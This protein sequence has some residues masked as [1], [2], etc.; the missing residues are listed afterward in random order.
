MRDGVPYTDDPVMFVEFT[1]KLGVGLFKVQGS[2]LSAS[3]EVIDEL[4]TKD[5][6]EGFLVEQIV[7]LAWDPAFALRAQSTSRY[8][9]VQMEVG[10]ELLI[11]GMQDSDK[12]QS[13][14]QFFL[15]KLDQ[16]LGDGFEEEA[17]HH[18][19]VL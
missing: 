15:P 18:R 19:F 1:F 4:A 16:G 2:P 6:G 11:P 9:A 7:L 3:S 14:S 17:K 5:Q 10:F 12:A 13:P 8:Q